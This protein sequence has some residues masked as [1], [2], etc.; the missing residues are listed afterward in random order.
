MG[1]YMGRLMMRIKPI[2]FRCVAGTGHH[3]PTMHSDNCWTSGAQALPEQDSA[4][5]PSLSMGETFQDPMD[6]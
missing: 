1:W 4:L 5:G 2:H 6:V 3:P